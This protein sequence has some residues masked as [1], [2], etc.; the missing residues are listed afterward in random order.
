LLQP[1]NDDIALVK[2]MRADNRQFL[3]V[4]TTPDRATGLLKAMQEIAWFPH[5]YLSA[6][7]ANGTFEWSPE[8]NE[9]IFLA[10][11]TAPVDITAEAVAEYSLLSEKYKIPTHNQA[12]QLAALAGAKIL[13]EALKR[14]G[15]DLTHDKL[16][17]S[18]ESISNF[19]TGFSPPVSYGPTRRIGAQGAYVIK[20][21][22][23]NKKFLPAWDWHTVN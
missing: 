22:L 20:L 10:F 8:F 19:S 12:L 23:A 5:V 6:V 3:F 14:S 1:E 2:Q 13:V 15:K 11:P 7:N 4:L 17:Q 16:I 9:K 21:D 18:L